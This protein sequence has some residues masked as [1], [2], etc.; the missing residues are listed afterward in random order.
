MFRDSCATLDLTWKIQVEE[1][2]PSD[3][4]SAEK[5][6]LQWCFSTAFSSQQFYS[7]KFGYGGRWTESR[8]GQAQGRGKAFEWARNFLEKRYDNND[9]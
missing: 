5:P 9:T 1:F 8:H 2:F 4:C 6:R 3:F 7:W